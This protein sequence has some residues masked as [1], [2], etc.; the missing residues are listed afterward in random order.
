MKKSVA[1]ALVVAGA[2]LQSPLAAQQAKTPASPMSYSQ[3]FVRDPPRGDQQIARQNRRREPR[4]DAHQ[5]GGLFGI[6]RHGAIMLP[7]RLY[8]GRP[9]E[10]PSTWLRT[11][12]LWS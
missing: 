10:V 9:L 2:L 5:Q 6:E 12:T 8:V 7:H 3:P 1:P 4:R 11:L